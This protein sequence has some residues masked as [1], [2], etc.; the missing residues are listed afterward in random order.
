M[1]RK[2]ILFFITSFIILFSLGLG[3]L[4]ER[5]VIRNSLLK[6]ELEAQL[7]SEHMLRIRVEDLV[8][9]EQGASQG[10]ELKDVAFR[11]GYNL[12]GD[13]VYYFS[14]PDVLD[15]LEA[16]SKVVTQEAP[17]S[18]FKGL[19]MHVLFIISLA[20]ATLILISLQVMRKLGG[21]RGQPGT[22]R[23]HDNIPQDDYDDYH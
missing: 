2:Y 23:R 9:T 7:Y 21:L 18:S 6:K 3:I 14:A 16:S 19:S 17:K 20:G 12:D 4:G 11:L 22:R 13:T 10:D 5:G 1:T 8:R 15:P